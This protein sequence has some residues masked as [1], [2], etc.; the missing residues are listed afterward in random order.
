MKTR[1]PLGAVVGPENVP[2]GSGGVLLKIVG[3]VAVAFLVAIATGHTMAAILIGL[4]GAGIIYAAIWLRPRRQAASDDVATL[5]ASMGAPTG[6][7]LPRNS[8]TAAWMRALAAG[9]AARQ[10]GI[11]DVALE[12]IAE[13][14]AEIG[15]VPT[16]V[17]A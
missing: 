14:I 13:I 9:L 5:Q 7:G 4:T 10:I 2:T 6:V 3:G 16:E 8:Q 17:S 15:P 12:A 11:D 1:G